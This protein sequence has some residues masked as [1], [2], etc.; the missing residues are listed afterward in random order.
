MRSFVIVTVL[1][2]L[3]S[4]AVVAAPAMHIA[5]P[6]PEALPAN[7]YD[8]QISIHGTE[9]LQAAEA[10]QQLGVQVGLPY[11]FEVGADVRLGAPSDDWPSADWR[12]WELGYNPDV[13]GWTDVWLNVK[14]QLFTETKSRPALAIGVLGIA[15]E[16][17]SS[18]WGTIGKHFGKL[19][20]CI[21]WSDAFEA[22]IPYELISYQPNEDWIFIAEHT[23]GS[24][25]STNFGVEHQINE[26]FTGTLGFM[27]ANDSFHDDALFAKLSYRN[28]WSK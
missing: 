15:S 2:L 12:N 20:V 28:S 3:V 7:T 4:S 9:M 25:M 22:N 26:N 18:F 5:V 13:E 10:E 19:G 6:L 14:K 16:E 11:G 21:G 24:L 23:G 27:R 1:S 8:V 17:G